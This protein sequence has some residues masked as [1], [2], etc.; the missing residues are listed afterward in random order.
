MTQPDAGAD[1]VHELLHKG[2][3]NII[4]KAVEAEL[5][6]FLEQLAYKAL[7]DSHCVMVRNGNC[8][9]RLRRCRSVRGLKWRQVSFSSALL[10]LYLKRVCKIEELIPWLYL[11]GF[12][13]GD[14]PKVLVALL[15]D[16]AK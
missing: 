7:E 13:T 16:K 1:L 6:T 3:R 2:A 12:S 9:E 11:K 14:Y 8:A 10:P 15:G 5:S 4:A